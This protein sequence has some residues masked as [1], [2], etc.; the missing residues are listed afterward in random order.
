MN[1]T[2]KRNNKGRL[3]KIESTICCVEGNREFYK[4]HLFNNKCSKCHLKTLSE[5]EREEFMKKHTAYHW[6]YERYPKK[7]LHWYTTDLQVS[8]NHGFIKL[9][10]YMLNATDDLFHNKIVFIKTLTSIPSMC[11]QNFPVQNTLVHY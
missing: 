9:L 5:T 3:V 8:D 7:D 10:T 4:Y 1:K 11:H 2:W 6:K